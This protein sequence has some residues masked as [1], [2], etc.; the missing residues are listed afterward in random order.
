VKTHIYQEKQATKKVPPHS[1]LNTNSEME[2]RENVQVIEQ[3]QL[4]SPNINSSSN[5]TNTT[6]TASKCLIYK[7]LEEESEEEQPYLSQPISKKLRKPK[8]TPQKEQPIKKPQMSQVPQ[9]SNVPQAPPTFPQKF[10]LLFNKKALKKIERGNVRH[11]F[12]KLTNNTTNYKKLIYILA[13]LVEPIHTQQHLAQLNI[14]TV[15]FEPTIMVARAEKKLQY[16]EEI[17]NMLMSTFGVTIH[18]R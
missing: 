18:E 16:R 3:E 8:R 7:D 17:A 14:L 1:T 5:P 9:A 2:E 15:F 4:G 6:S 13:G 11:Y 12:F 10:K